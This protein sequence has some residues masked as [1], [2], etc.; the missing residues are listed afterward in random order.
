M[1]H[2]PNDLRFL[3][4]HYLSSFVGKSRLGPLVT[5]NVRHLVITLCGLVQGHSLT[6]RQSYMVASEDSSVK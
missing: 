1:F 6:C 5:Y 4:A 3:L 2:L